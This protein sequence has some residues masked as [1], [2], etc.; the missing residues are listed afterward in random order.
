MF[1][2]K[3]D[4]E[5]YEA[6]ESIYVSEASN[7]AD[8]DINDGDGKKNFLHYLYFC[9]ALKKGYIEKGIPLKYLYDNLEDVNVWTDI[10]SDLKGELYLGVLDWFNGIYGMETYKVGRLQYKIKKSNRDIPEVSLKKGDNILEVHIPAR[11]PLCED[12]CKVSFKQTKIFFE[13]LLL[14]EKIKNP[15]KK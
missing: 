14:Q 13:T 9:E 5:F 12:E 4:R 8:Y 1:P 6:L 11:G 2:S 10:W 7:Y 3:Y 15:I